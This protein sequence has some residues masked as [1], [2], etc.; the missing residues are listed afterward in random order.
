M[1]PAFGHLAITHHSLPLSLRYFYDQFFPLLSLSQAGAAG[2]S[3]GLMNIFSRATGGAISDVLGKR[4]GMR[5]RLWWL[6]S[7]QT[8]GGVF[9]IILGST[10][11]STSFNSTIGIVIVFSLF[12]E[13]R[14]C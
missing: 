9:C 14:S 10:A 1:C 4:F 12:T 3:F 6:W 5:A 11:V 7:I 13:V 8:L 2:S